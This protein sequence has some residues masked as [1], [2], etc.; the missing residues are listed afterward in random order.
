MRVTCHI[1]HHKTGTTSLQAFLSQNSHRLAQAGILY[2]WTEF[3]GAA[4][5]VSKAMGAGDRKAVLP[6]NIREPHNALAFRMLSDALPAWKVPPHHPNLPHSRQM[7][8]AVANQMAALEPKEV[9]LCS[10]VMSHFGKSA[11]S[12]ITRLRKNGL[13]LAD[14]FTLW[15]TLRRPD[16]QLVA[17]HG[18]QVRF[19]QAPKP[20]SDTEHG[21]KLKWLHV[22]YR[23]VVE[24]WINNIPEARVILRPYGETVS[25]GGSVEDFVQGSGLKWP[26]NLLPAKTM[27]V[28]FKPAVISLLRLANGR[29]SREHAQ[30]LA[31]RSPALTRGMKLAGKSEV[32]FLGQESRAK[33]VAHFQPIHDWLTSVSGRPVFFSDIEE[34]AICRP[35]FETDALQQLLD[36]LTPSHIKTIAAPEVREF[37]TDLRNTGAML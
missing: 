8:V 32:E 24:P 23:G 31:D 36:Q 25:N 11:T 37:L 12:Q 4:H 30:D 9:V 2:P 27:N 34:M 15:C 20:L 21:L 35:I 22:D 16:E 6:F 28:S 7:L 26:A 5:A 1:G 13:S 33:L 17:W 14:A 10:E 3:E 29:L 19:G 18:Q